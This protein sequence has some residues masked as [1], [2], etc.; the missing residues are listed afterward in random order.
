[1]G[2]GRFYGRARRLPNFDQGSPQR[3]HDRPK[4][5][6]PFSEQCLKRRVTIPEIE[7]NS[8]VFNLRPSVKS[9]DISS[10]VTEDRRSTDFADSHREN[11]EI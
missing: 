6:L 3:R 7:S 2:A 9:A 1:V 11:G 8:S 5:A 10:F 4:Q